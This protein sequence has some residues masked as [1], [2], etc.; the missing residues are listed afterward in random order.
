MTPGQAGAH[1][2]RVERTRTWALA[3]PVLAGAAVVSAALVGIDGYGFWRETLAATIAYSVVGGVLTFLRPNERVAWLL[4]AMGAA[5]AL[6]L[7]CGAWAIAHLDS[8]PW[9]PLAGVLSTVLQTAGVLGIGHLLLRFPT[10]R[11]HSRLWGIVSALL[12]GGAVLHAG[13]FALSPR[14]LEDFRYAESPVGP[15]SGASAAADAG[16]VLWL[17]ATALALAS[18]VIRT[19]RSSGRERQQYGWFLYAAI[20]TAVLLAAPGAAGVGDLGWLVGPGALAAGVAAASVFHGLYDVRVVVSR[21]VAF[22]AASAVLVAGYVGVVAG[23]RGLV[24]APDTAA[25]IV[26]TALVA[27]SFAPVFALTN[28]AVERAFYGARGAPDRLLSGLHHQLQAI[29]EPT[30]VLASIAD[31]IALGLRVPYVAIEVDDAGSAHTGEL[32]A[33][34][35]P[36]EFPLIYQGR[37]IGRLVAGA[38]PRRRPPRHPRPRRPRRGGRAGRRRGARGLAHGLAARLPDPPSDGA[39]GGAAPDPPRP[40]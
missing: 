22:A 27:V 2:G 7:L 26:A 37:P 25:G 13:A 32:P 34:G 17:A 39:G 24:G 29:S 3:E 23:L 33:A 28:R 21:S 40:A 11:V 31:T 19:R 14:A 38:A 6:Q 15:V 1:H 5:S 9:G 10:G 12:T 35:E 8:R 16:G 18:L 36:A 4:A 30:A 20:L